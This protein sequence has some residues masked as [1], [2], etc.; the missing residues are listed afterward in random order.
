MLIIL[1]CIKLFII[2][3]AHHYRG[4]QEYN[5]KIKMYKLWENYA[6]VIIIGFIIVA[7]YTGMEAKL[8]Y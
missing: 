7:H 4:Q 8:L 5:Y 6:V 3:L 1:G 2:W